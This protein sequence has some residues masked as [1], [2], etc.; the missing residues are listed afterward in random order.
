MTQ[1]KQTYLTLF[2]NSHQCICMILMT[3]GCTPNWGNAELSTPAIFLIEWAVH[4]SP[5]V[6]STYLN[7]PVLRLSKLNSAFDWFFRMFCSL[8]VSLQN[9]LFT[10]GCQST[11]INKLHQCL[12]LW[13]LTRIEQKKLAIPFKQTESPHLW[14]I[15]GTMAFKRHASQREI[16][17]WTNQPF[18]GSLQAHL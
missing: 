4:F 12:N 6:R 8:Q 3:F 9:N 15:R 5:C 11:T 1:V 14:P 10:F 18:G 17:P 16:Y 7:S 13:F 2:N